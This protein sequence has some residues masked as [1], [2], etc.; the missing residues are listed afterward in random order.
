MFYLECTTKLKK[1]YFENLDALLNI[2]LKMQN[3]PIINNATLN[4][5]SEET[6][7]IIEKMYNLCHYYYIFAIIALINADLSEDKPVEIKLEK[8]YS[9]VFKA[10]S[11]TN[12]STNSKSNVQNPSTNSKSNVQNPSTNSKS[13]VQNPSTNSIPNNNSKNSK[14]S[15]V[16]P[17][18]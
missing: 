5:I 4:I 16:V 15:I 13:N 12:P 7:A 8:V 6:K 10:N 2:L 18:H 17:E 1:N 3:I 9:E 11:D 14:K